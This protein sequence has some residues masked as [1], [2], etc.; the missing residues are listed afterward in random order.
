VAVQDGKVAAEVTPR[1][2]VPKRGRPD[3]FQVDSVDAFDDQERN[4]QN[5][6]RVVEGD[7]AG[8]PDAG[9]DG[10]RDRRCLASACAMWRG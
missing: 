7:Q 8:R 9:L 3:R 4:R 1:V 10:E 5:L 6:K 2:P